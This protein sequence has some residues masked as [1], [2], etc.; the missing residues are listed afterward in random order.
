MTNSSTD[1]GEGGHL[2]EQTQTARDEEQ[3]ARVLAKRTLA[4]LE[5]A[6]ATL[7]DGVRLRSLYQAQERIARAGAAEAAETLNAVLEAVAQSALDLVPGATHV[8]LILRDEERDDSG[9]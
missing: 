7:K 1:G 5:P 4:E 9:A 8:T 3:E 6:D 2:R